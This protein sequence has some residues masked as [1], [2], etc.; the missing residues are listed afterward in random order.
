MVGRLGNPTTGP[1][2][3]KGNSDGVDYSMHCPPRTRIVT[4]DS[5]TRIDHRWV[6]PTWIDTR[7]K[8]HADKRTIGDET[9]HF[10]DSPWLWGIAAMP[11][12]QSP[13]ARRWDVSRPSAPAHHRVALGVS[14]R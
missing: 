7:G 1:A 5:P 13:D 12:T 4:G 3:P 9:A 6:T 10:A 11:I 14:L 8:L 2:S